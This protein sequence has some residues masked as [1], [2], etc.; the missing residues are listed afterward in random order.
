M[1]AP[2][3]KTDI[4]SGATEPIRLARAR[5]KVR[6]ISV[7]AVLALSFGT[8][9][10][11]SVGGV[12]AL[13]VGA[14]YRNTIDL[15]LAQ[16]DLLVDAMDDSLRDHMDRAAGTVDGLSK[17]Y[18][19]RGFEID[20][21]AAMNAAL[22][23]ALASVPEATAIFIYTDDNVERGVARDSD[24][25]SGSKIVRFDPKVETAPDVLAA[26]EL[27]RKVDGVRWGAFVSNE[28]GLFANVSAPMVRDGK[29][30]GYVIAPV[31]LQTLSKLTRDLSSRFNTT[32]FILDGDSRVI[33]HQRLA[34]PKAREQGIVPLQP[35]DKLGDEVL[36]HFSTR[37]IVGEPGDTARENLEIA[38]IGLDGN[39]RAS[40][41]WDEERSYVVVTRD[42]AGYSDRPWKI[43]AYFNSSQLGAELQR[44]GASA[45]LGLGGLAAAVLA[46][47]LLGR[48]LARPVK[49]IAGHA[50]RVA[51]FDVAELAPLPSSRV[52]ELDDQATAFNAML[53]GLRAFSTYIPRSLV[54]KLVR[55]GEIG[56]AE[57]R[58]ATLTVMFTDIADFTGL[59]ERMD[60]AETARLLNRHFEILCRAVDE[61]GGTVDKFLGDGMMAFF[62]A[63]DQ[64]KDH[65]AAAVRAAARIRA[66]LEA[67]NELVRAEGRPA[68][69][70]RIG[71]HTG[72]V[73]V[74]NI[75][76][77]DRVNYTIIGDTVN[78]SQ[79]LQGLGKTLAPDA[80]TAIVVSGE[81]A[82]RLDDRFEMIDAGRHSLR[83]RGEAMEV[84]LVGAVDMAAAA[85][86]RDNR[87]A[88]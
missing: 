58:E 10:L 46:A 71:I 79:R 2:A 56:I 49:A 84:Y 19:E 83:G 81:T 66:D 72:Q 26:L 18:A 59:S 16:A 51:A 87:S 70:V 88:A 43:G 38:E 36:A 86:S 8:L 3:S 44:A 67:D 52:R 34:D 75:G 85:P 13:S 11:L 65:A 61:T 62:G 12:L 69:K 21:G 33:A 27:R 78:V 15:L 41:P 50:Q 7:A 28:F 42:I 30:V 31:E 60:A 68:F 39:D 24:D 77:S 32:A 29:R 57:P 23:G 9:V 45:L 1:K 80:E 4:M 17:F 74:G 76:A 82:S 63:P 48:R 47:I 22:S 54:A 53:I 40:M 20:D 14:N 37:S 6:R 25:A 35:L 64:L 73:T 55:T 5:S